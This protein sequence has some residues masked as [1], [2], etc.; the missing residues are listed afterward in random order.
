M[1]RPASRDELYGIRG[2]N[3]LDGR[4]LVVVQLERD[5]YQGMPS[6]MPKSS[7]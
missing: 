1:D 2:R 4:K 7:Y 3:R 6:G 5:S